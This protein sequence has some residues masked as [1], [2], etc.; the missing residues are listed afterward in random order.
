MKIKINKGMP[1]KILAQVEKA[2]PKASA[3]I[4]A[5]YPH[6]NIDEAKINFSHTRNSSNYVHAYEGATEFI[7][8]ATHGEIRMYEKVTCGL[9]T[10]HEGLNVGIELQIIT[11][12]IHE[13]T[14]Y[15]QGVE[16]RV[17]SEVETT[18]NEIEYLKQNEPF[19]Y[20]CLV[21]II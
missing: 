3:F 7:N 20:N 21:P 18:R 9:T 12:L 1:K 15:I 19:W 10:P 2:I 14:H 11:A 16:K 8:I 17:Y 13:L 6:I 4:K 5:K